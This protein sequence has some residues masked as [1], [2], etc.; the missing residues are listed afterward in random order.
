M[1]SLNLLS[2]FNYSM[3]CVHSLCEH[4][5]SRCSQ[6]KEMEHAYGRIGVLDNLVVPCCS[7]HN[8]HIENSDIKDW[9]KFCFIVIY[10]M[11]FL[12]SL[13]L[14]KDWEEEFR[15]LYYKYYDIYGEKNLSKKIKQIQ[16]FYHYYD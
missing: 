14:K 2:K 12:N 15:R 5:A 16:E 6:K 11:E 4:T 7:K 10:G 8:S 13:D 3:P 1:N 9:N